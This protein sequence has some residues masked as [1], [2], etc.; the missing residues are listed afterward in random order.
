MAE[1]Q[2]TW[3]SSGDH[4]VPEEVAETAQQLANARRVAHLPPLQA[5]AQLISDNVP[6]EDTGALGVSAGTNMRFKYLLSGPFTF[7]IKTT[8]T[9]TLVRQRLP[10]E[11]QA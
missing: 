4:A 2:W 7:P 3:Q 6:P 9:Y 10:A 1:F 8:A 5:V 11:G